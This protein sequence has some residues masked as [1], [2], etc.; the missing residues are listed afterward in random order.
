MD[1]DVVDPVKGSGSGD[2][3][4]KLHYKGSREWPLSSGLTGWVAG[5]LLVSQLIQSVHQESL[6]GIEERELNKSSE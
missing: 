1:G 2:E 3:L 4:E 6:E 5:S